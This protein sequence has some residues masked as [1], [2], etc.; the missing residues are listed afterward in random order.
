MTFWALPLEDR[1]AQFLGGHTFDTYRDL[2]K[3]YLWGETDA[4]SR[5]KAVWL[6]CRVGSRKHGMII[7]VSLIK[8]VGWEWDTHW[9]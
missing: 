1:S 4:V 6:P 8:E 3:I 2:V 7:T 9:G 5:H